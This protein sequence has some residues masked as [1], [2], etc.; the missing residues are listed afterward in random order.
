MIS[1]KRKLCFLIIL[2]LLLIIVSFKITACDCDNPYNGLTDEDIN[3]LQNL[4]EIEDWSFTVGKN[5]ATNYS[6]DCICGFE[7]PEDWWVGAPFDPCVPT[8]DLPDYFDWRDQGGCTPV[9]SQGGCG[10]CWAFSAI[11]ALECS[12][13]IKDNVTVDLSEQWLVSDCCPSCGDCGGGWYYTAWNYMIENSSYTDSCGD[14]G[15]VLEQDFPY[16]A[17]DSPCGCPYPHPYSVGSWSFIGSGGGSTPPV[18]SIKQAIMD[19]GPVSVAVAANDAMSA[20][21]G[22]IFDGCT[23]GSIN[24][25]VVLVGWDDNQG[26][27]GVWFMRNSWGTGWGEDGGYMRIPYG[28]SSIGYAAAYLKYRDPITVDLPYGLPETFIPGEVTNITVKINEI[29]DTYVPDSGMTHYRYDDGDFQITSLMHLSGELY[30]ATFPPANC[31]DSPEY[32]FT[33]EG[34][35]TGTVCFPD[36]APNNTF[37]SLVGELTSVFTDDFETDKGWTVVND[38]GLTDGAWE[39]GIPVGGGD[40]GDPPEDY[41]GSGHCYLTDNEDGNS[42]VDDGLTWLISP[43]LNLAGGM[44]AKIDF[45]LWYNNNYGNDPNNDIFKVYVSNDDGAS[46]VLVESIGPVTQSG[47]EKR[48]FMVGDFLFPNDQVRVR[49]EAS[50]L[51]DGSVVEAGI[52]AFN[53]YEFTCV[54]PGNVFISNLNPNWNFISLPFNQ[55]INKADITVNDNGDMYSWTD[56]ANFNIVSDFIFG[57]DRMGQTYTLPTMVDP[58]YGYWMYAYEPCELW[59][60]NITVPSD[61]YITDAEQNWNIISVPYDENV[62]KTDILVNDISWDDAVTAGIVNDVVF[63]WDRDWQSYN[64][65]DTLMPGYAYWMYAYFDCTLQK[66]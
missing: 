17:S 2:G 51:N 12:I 57:W 65:A 66:L 27:N 36:G 18:S 29:A 41:D 14:S 43:S 6:L 31:G 38:P 62:S 13:L 25:A 10:S 21:T 11:G 56:A 28:C 32:Y 16:Q 3:E 19:Y 48:G 23:S 1:N 26:D 44:D 33:A 49:F 52:D 54:A 50:D 34:N 53:A 8:R 60:E 59:I 20:Y 22:G 40:R 9:K 64:F 7:L 46:W 58:G 5:S 37:S 42:D 24:H 55:S 39:R 61:D 35:R 4:A 47:W 63:G 45:A 15:A 30:V